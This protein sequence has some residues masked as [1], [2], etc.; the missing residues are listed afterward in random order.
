MVK[1]ISEFWQV[2]LDSKMKVKSVELVRTKFRDWLVSKGVYR[3]PLNNKDDIYVQITDNIAEE[4][5]TKKIKKM[6][7]DYVH[8]LPERFDMITKT[9]LEEFIIKGAKIYFGKDFL[10]FL[11]E[12]I[13]GNIVCGKK[14]KWN[15]DTRT[16]SFFTLKRNCIAIVD[17]EGLNKYLIQTFIISFGKIK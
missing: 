4:I 10:D 5:N 1:D 16:H 3:M 9:I 11:P 17:K 15:R 14:F 8:T 6:V 13:E 2:N 7:I 12:L